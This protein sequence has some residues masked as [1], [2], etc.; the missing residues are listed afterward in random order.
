MKLSARL[1]SLLSLAV[2]L[3]AQALPVDR[4]AVWFKPSLELNSD[5]ICAG[6]LQAEQN[7]FFSTEW[8]DDRSTAGFQ[9]IYERY[10]PFVADP[11][12]ERQGG[13]DNEFVLTL[14]AGERVVARFEHHS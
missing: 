12:V 5:P 6:L 13:F 7:V 8:A 14:P 3:T 4:D 11:R 10:L 9:R 1:V 2:V